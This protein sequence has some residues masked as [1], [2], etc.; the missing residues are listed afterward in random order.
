MCLCCFIP[1][2]T[3][4][5]PRSRRAPCPSCW[6]T[7][8]HQSALLPLLFHSPGREGRVQ[9]Q[10]VPHARAAGAHA[11]A[12][13]AAEPPHCVRARGL[14]HQQPRHDS[15]V[16]LCEWR[17]WGKRVVWVKG[18][19]GW[20]RLSWCASPRAVRPATPR[21][22]SGVRLVECKDGVRGLVRDTGKG[23]MGYWLGGKAWWDTSLAVA[24]CSPRLLPSPAHRCSLRTHPRRSSVAQVLCEV[25]AMYRMVRSGVGSDR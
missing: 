8:S 16:R 13:Q 4:P 19:G 9:G 17:G 22:D 14:R 6:S 25:A 20:G 23:L 10:G 15:G 18:G 3:R 5:S 1:R 12:A 24:R 7:P 21:H 11:A 2:T